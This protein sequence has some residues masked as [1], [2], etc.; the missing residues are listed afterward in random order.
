MN[1]DDR[2]EDGH[3]LRLPIEFEAFFELHHQRYLDYAR[4]Q[5]SLCEPEQIQDL[6]ED[7]L[8]HLGADWK[9]VLQRANPT[10]YAWGA[11]RF[12]VEHERRQRG[13]VLRLVEKAVFMA[14]ASRAT[15]PVFEALEDGLGV[16]DAISRLPERQYD[17]LLLKQFLGYTTAQTADVMGISP[18]TV[19]A[20]IHQARTRLRKHTLLAASESDEE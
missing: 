12:A 2:S 16:Y 20:L 1:H 8:A 19:R 11:L 4:A 3:D 18:P 13:E 14:A 6:V 15:R 9:R 10:N 5:L 17:A 7:V